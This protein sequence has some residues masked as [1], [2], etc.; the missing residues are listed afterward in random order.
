MN[1]QN[2]INNTQINK[3]QEI[4][5]YNNNATFYMKLVHNKI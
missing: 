1:K 3:L 4:V 5:I 2:I